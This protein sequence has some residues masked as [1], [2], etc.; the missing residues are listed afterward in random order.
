MSYDASADP[1]SLVVPA[2]G[3]A[4]VVP[5]VNTYR[6]GVKIANTGANDVYVALQKI[7]VAPL[8]VAQIVAGQ[9]SYKIPSGYTDN[10][11]VRANTQINVAGTIAG[12]C[13]YQ[14][15]L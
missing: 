10:I 13:A 8:T 15:V 5:V 14:D 3:A 6:S 9:W 12:T 4:G 2:S 1:T 11:D 7:G